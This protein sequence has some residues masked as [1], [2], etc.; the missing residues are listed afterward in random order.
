MS[1][2]VKALLC[3]TA[4]FTSA[5]LLIS[6]HPILEKP[7]FSNFEFPWGNYIT[8]VGFIAFPFGVLVSFSFLR[9]PTSATTRLLKNLL[10]MNIVLGLLWVPISYLLSGNLKNSFKDSGN[11]QGSH[12][13]SEIF[14][15]YCELLVALP[16]LIYICSWILQL[17]G[18]SK[19][20]V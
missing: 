16:L 6:G 20:Q 13:A 17:L 1:H 12:L 2:R 8:W 11:F 10:R 7:I 9:K 4:V 3:F 5:Y 14:W 19:K 15:L 18:R